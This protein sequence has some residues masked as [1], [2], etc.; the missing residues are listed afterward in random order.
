MRDRLALGV[1]ATGFREVARLETLAVDAGL[2]VRAVVVEATALDALLV[3]A[4]LAQLAL[5]IGRAL[6]RWAFR[7][8]ASDH[9]E[10]KTEMIMIIQLNNAAVMQ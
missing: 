3:L 7:N 6:G 2:V 8:C 1:L 5:V 10:E 9:A 4:V